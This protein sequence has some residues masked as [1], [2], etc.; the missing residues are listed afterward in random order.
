MYII[1]TDAN[2]VQESA[3]TKGFSAATEV[4]WA[5]RPTSEGGYIVLGRSDAKI[6]QVKLDAGGNTQWYKLHGWD[7]VAN[8]ALAVQQTFD[9]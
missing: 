9:G 7:G 1:K 8:R 4:G 6:F 3:Q 2:G 5:G